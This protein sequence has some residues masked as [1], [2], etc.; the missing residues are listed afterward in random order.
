MAHK[1]YRRVVDQVFGRPWALLPAKLEQIAELVD[2]RASGVELSEEEIRLRLGFEI[3]DPE[4]LDDAAPEAP[5]QV[6]DG[7]A[8]VPLYGLI[9]QRVNLLQRFSGGTS[10]Q[11]F[12]QA[13]D[14][15]LADDAVRSIVLDVDSPGGSVYGTPEAAAKVFAGRGRKPIYAVANSLMASAAYWI[16]SAADQ[17]VASRSADVGSIGVYQMH[18]DRSA[19][20]AKAGIRRTIVKAGEFKALGNDVEPLTDQARARMQAEIDQVYQLFLADVARFRRASIAEVAAGFGRGST[21]MG[22][23]AVAAR[24]ADRV[25]TLDDVV[26]ELGRLAKSFSAAVAPQVNAKGASMFSAKVI[27]AAVAAGI[28]GE[29]VTGEAAEQAVAAWFATNGGA[30]STEAAQVRALLS[31]VEGEGELVA[32]AATPPAQRVDS[33]GG[34]DAALLARG[35]AEE[36]YRATTIRAKCRG[37]GLGDDV[38][39]EM[40]DAGVTLAQIDGELVQRLSAATPPVPR[41]QVQ[42]G[43]AASDK[44]FAAA[45]EALAARCAN[46]VS[47]STNDPELAGVASGAATS[48]ALSPAAVQLQH[49]R[50]IDL[51][52]LSLEQQGA[53]IAGL[54]PLRIAELALQADNPVRMA[55]V[56]AFYTTGSFPN[57]ALNSARKTLARAYADT[58]VTWRAWVPVGESVAD[59]KVNSIVKF[60]GAGDMEVKPENHPTPDDTGLDDDREYFQVETYARKVALSREMILNDDLGALAR[61]PAKQGVGAARTWN[62]LVYAILTGNPTMADGYSLFDTTN[63]QG[64][65]L[66]S[67]AAPTVAQLNAMEAVLRKMDGLHADELNLNLPLIYLIVPAALGGTTRELLFSQSNPASSNSGVV[68]IHQG[69]VKPIVEGL[70]DGNSATAYY[71]ATDPTLCDTI[72]VRFLQGEETPQLTSWYDDDRGC[73]WHKVQQT[74]AAVLVDYRGLIKNPGA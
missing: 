18:V 45:E 66:A 7:V 73:R 22:D 32:A 59:F 62:K 64:N 68:N 12:G 46:Q 24:L 63:H 30:P 58:P 16:G 11:L 6:T 10:T 54:A 37:V 50:L 49:K 33:R 3:D 65:L 60:S 25:A 41:V 67:G 38:A 26:A 42:T 36:R 48:R 72:E 40:I 17:V 5:Y 69:I 74:G 47:R 51:A 44:F 34:D 31:A 27:A 23:A 1:K 4:Q 35:R 21:E 71:G 43:A 8:V 29:G 19:A 39:E 55:S 70:L 56:G 52:A 15:A 9:A 2:L 57:L 13:I 61:I 28:V 14:K 53:R 20:D